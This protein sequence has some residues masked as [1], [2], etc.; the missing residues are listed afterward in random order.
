M[1]ESFLHHCTPCGA[2]TWHEVVVFDDGF[3]DDTERACV[4]CGSAVFVSVAFVDAEL[5]EVPVAA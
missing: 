3:G 1:A 4:D 2:E 5:F